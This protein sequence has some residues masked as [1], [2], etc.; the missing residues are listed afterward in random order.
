MSVH[1]FVLVD[2]NK[3]EDR[4]SVLDEFDGVI[5]DYTYSALRDAIASSRS[6][7]GRSEEHTSELQSQR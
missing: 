6:K 1:R 7:D 3:D 5:E 2:I 4:Y